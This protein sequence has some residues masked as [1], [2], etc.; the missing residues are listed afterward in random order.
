MVEGL[1]SLCGG[2]SALR[3]VFQVLE[4]NLLLPPVDKS[5]EVSSSR[6]GAFIQF[7][8]ALEL[9]DFLLGVL[10]PLHQIWNDVGLLQVNEAHG[11]FKIVVGPG[12]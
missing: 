4:V 11:Q 2:A 5:T 12:G 6:S 10:C 1:D 3:L 9:V 7:K 8:H